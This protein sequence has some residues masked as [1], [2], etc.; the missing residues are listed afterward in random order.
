[1]WHGHECAHMAN[2]DVLDGDGELHEFKGVRGAIAGESGNVRVKG[3]DDGEQQFPD[4]TIVA[5]VDPDKWD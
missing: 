3:T 4:G 1:M 5:V 2:V